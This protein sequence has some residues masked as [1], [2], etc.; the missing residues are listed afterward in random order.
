MRD[1]TVHRKKGRVAEASEPSADNDFVNSVKAVTEFPRSSFEFYVWSDEGLNLQ[2]DLTSS[3]SDWTNKFKKEVRVSENM[4]GNKSW[5]LR[6]DLSGLQEKSSLLWNTSYYQV[7]DRY[8]KATSSSSGLKLTKDSDAQLGQLNNGKRPL[9]SYS[10]TPNEC[11]EDCGLPNGSC[12]VNPG[13]VLAGASLSSSVEL[14]NSEVASCHKYASVSPRDNEGSLDLSDPKNT[15]E[16][17]QGRPINSSEINFV[18]DGNDFPSQTEKWEM[19]KIVDGRKRSRCSQFDDPLRKSSLDSNDQ[20]SKTELCEKRK[21]SH[22]E[23]QGS[24]SPATRILRSMTKTSVMVLPRRSPR[25][26]KVL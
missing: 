25:L 19:T 13:V 7:F 23:I 18:T 9:I 22:S 3:P 24:S 10:L 14:Q 2:V 8:G 11:S 16:L 4:S 17:K 20:V 21:N 1:K 26:S 6:Q 15:S 12:N 5:S